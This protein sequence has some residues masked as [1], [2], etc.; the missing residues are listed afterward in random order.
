MAKRRRVLVTGATGYLGSA[1]FERSRYAEHAEPLDMLAPD[2]EVRAALKGAYALVHFAGQVPRPGVAEVEYDALNRVPTQNLAQLCD[3]AG[4]R[5]LYASTGSMYGGVAGESYAEHEGIVPLADMHP[6]TKSKYE[7]EQ[8]IGKM[9]GLRSTILRLGTIFGSSPKQNAHSPVFTFLHNARTNGVITVWRTA[10]AQVRPY[11]WIG[12]VVA[13]IDFC[14]DRDIF[15]RRVYNVVSENTTVD[16]V[17]AL[18]REQYPHTRIELV[19]HER[20]NNLSYAM[21]DT[22]IRSEGFVPQ[23]SIATGLAELGTRRSLSLR[24][25]ILAGGRGTRLAPLTLTVNKHFLPVYDKPLILWPVMTLVRLGVD[26]ITIVSN[27][28]DE[29]RYRELLGDGHTLGVS[30]DYVVQPEA[31]GVAGALLAAERPGS[32][33][34]VVVHLGDNIFFDSTELGHAV[35]RFGAEQGPRGMIFLKEVSD[36]QRFGIAGVSDGKVVSLEEKPE[37]P[38][39]SLAVT[40]LYL[41][42]H[43]VFDYVRTLAPSN[44]GELEI[45]DVNKA[46]LRTGNLTY[47]ILKGEWIDAGT[48]ES[49]LQANVMA[50]GMDYSPDRKL[51]ILFGINKLAVGGAEHLVLH[52]LR[53]IAKAHFEPH[54]VTLLPSREPNLD[55]EAAF[56]GKRWK[57]F[58]FSGFLDIPSWIRL[59]RYVRRE[60]FDVV[61]ANLFFTSIIL[62][63]VA[64]LAG[65]PVILSAELNAYAK[66]NPRWLPFERLIARFTDRF[67]ASSRDVVATTKRELGVPDEKITLSYNAID[68]A[69]RGAAASPEAR[70]HARQKWGVGEEEF[71]VVT[72]GRLV[73]QK[74]QRYLIEAFAEVATQFPDRS[75]RLFIFGEGVL[76][77]SLEKR[78]H[79]LGVAD[80]VV[81]AGVAPVP[82]IVALADVFV[83]PSLWEGLSLMLLEAMAAQNPVIATDVSGSR[84]L[85]VDGES[86]YLV[87]PRNPGALRD[88][89][90]K[91]IADPDLRARFVRRST[92]EV[93]RF[94]IENNLNNLYTIIRTTRKAK[95]L[96]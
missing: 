38:A 74:G 58:S 12:D 22:A 92:K 28:E 82:D 5:F 55:D 68:L 14:L 11:T 47:H 63:S 65:V 52:Q 72:A 20:M 44:R 76:R 88:A 53:N 64:R 61:V 33:E 89:L 60:R 37:H 73:E 51:K 3:E 56:L 6:Y 46:Y 83:L 85:I 54:L 45:T 39:S 41:Y 40:G 77:D 32:L 23:G 35:E 25:I 81:F 21:D 90:G 18:V 43:T 86:G 16:Q 26:S 95:K 66:R 13:A 2:E 1:F 19:D 50:A 84:E 17:L 62:R 4:V 71:V 27:P 7:A 10:P 42:D 24:G 75:L 49:L 67:I 70:N 93:Q 36:P 80:R 48:H 91:L 15:K 31:N 30:I 57:K 59:Y 96:S 78:A 79:E 9:V 29:I 69:A 34:D 87:P 8:D 94:S